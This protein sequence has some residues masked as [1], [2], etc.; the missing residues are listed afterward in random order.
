MYEVQKCTIVATS[1][2]RPSKPNS[3]RKLLPHWGHQSAATHLAV[4][5]RRQKS[6]NRA[7]GS[8]SHRRRA[9][10]ISRRVGLHLNGEAVI[11]GAAHCLLRTVRDQSVWL[12]RCGKGAQWNLQKTLLDHRRCWAEDRAN[13]YGR[14]S[15]CSGRWF[16]LHSPREEDIR[17]ASEGWEDDAREEGGDDGHGDVEGVHGG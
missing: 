4:Q 12:V 7:L 8:R 10:E 13:R 6:E 14:L 11:L 9:G 16:R 1:L 2:L 15:L 5:N 3:S 17:R